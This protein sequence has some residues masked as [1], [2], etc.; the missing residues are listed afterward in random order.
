MQ[1]PTFLRRWVVADGA[2]PDWAATQTLPPATILADVDQVNTLG[3]TFVA[4]E[5]D[6]TT[7]SSGTLDVQLVDVSLPAPFQGGTFAPLVTGAP[8]DAAI[9][10]GEG[11]IYDVRGCRAVTI[12]VSASAL[13]PAAA[14]VVFF[15]RALS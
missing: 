6:G 5:A 10:C 11:L 13:D 4:F 1:V 14:S 7:V 2:D 15:W 8:V 3:V 12:R 9:N